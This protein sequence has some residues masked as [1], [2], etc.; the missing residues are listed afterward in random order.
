LGNST[1]QYHVKVISDASAG[2][3]FGS[4]P[5]QLHDEALEWMRSQG[6]EIITSADL[7]SMGCGI[8]SGAHRPIR[9]ALAMILATGLTMQSFL[10]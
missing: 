10:L 2:L 9:M 1:G 6:A 5:T 4:T 3:P 7:L 8:I